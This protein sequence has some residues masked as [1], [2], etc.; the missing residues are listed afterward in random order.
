MH[1]NLRR[2]VQTM[3]GLNSYLCLCYLLVILLLSACSTNRPLRPNTLSS[4]PPATWSGKMSLTLE[5]DPKQTFSAEFDLQGDPQTGEMQF[6]T[7]L[8]TTLA[9]AKW[10]SSGAELLGQGNQTQ[11]FSSLQTLSQKYM[12]ATLPV[13]MIFAWANGAVFN[14][15]NGWSVVQ[16]TRVTSATSATSEMVATG[17]SEFRAT[18]QY[19]LPV[20]QLRIWLKQTSE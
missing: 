19:P 17:Q 20:V 7:S 18:R 2:P 5:T 12:G 14:V 15:P 4:N 13:E 1:F 16:S 10:D 3:C 8:G 6:Y 11:R 9:Q